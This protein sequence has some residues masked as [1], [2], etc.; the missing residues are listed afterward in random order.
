M[1]PVPEDLPDRARWEGLKGIGMAISDTVRD[2]KACDEVRYY[3]LS[4]KSARAAFR[5]QRCAS[6]WGIENRCT[7]NWT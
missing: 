6:H 3:I 4:K 7:G 5:A 2:G 1:C